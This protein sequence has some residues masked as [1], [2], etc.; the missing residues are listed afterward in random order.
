MCGR[1]AVTLP[2]DAM[3]Q[4]FGASP[5][6]NLPSLPNFN[7]CPTDPVHIVTSDTGR[8]RRLRAMRWGF[9]PHWYKKPAGGPLLINA[10]AET[11]ADLP[12]FRDA[13]RMRRGVILA[14]GF[15]EWQKDAEGN[16]NPWY[17]F[18]T[19][20]EPLAFAAVWQNWSAPSGLE[21]GDQI[22][23]CAIVTTQ[24]NEPMQSIHHRM[25]VVLE[26]KDWALWLG[27]AGKGAAKLM[28]PAADDLLQWYR[29][30]RAVN[31]NRASGPALITPLDQEGAVP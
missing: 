24:A 17:I 21:N 20:Q 4:L 5:A 3:A 11:L 22:A 8:S 16:R 13:A 2:P 23:T 9:I 26:Q 27:E 15:Y 29:V 6:N 31:S 1:M 7:V 10:R 18:R 12:A 28:Q 30:D 25:P 19:D 14:S